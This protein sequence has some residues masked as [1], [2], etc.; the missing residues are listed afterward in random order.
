MIAN[1]QI[2]TQDVLFSYFLMGGGSGECVN[3]CYSEKLTKFFPL[4]LLYLS[5][6]NSPIVS[7]IQ[8]QKN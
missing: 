3:F 7:A 6:I 8:A 4:L 5:A 2:K 1:V